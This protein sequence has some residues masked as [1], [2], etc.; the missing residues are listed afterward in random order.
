MR[1]T[2]KFGIIGC[3]VIANNK[4]MPWLKRQPEAELV[5]FCD[6]KK[7]K[8]EKAAK[9]YGSSTAK[10]YTDYREL[11]K[12]EDIDVVHVLVP[13]RAH[14]EITIAAFKA[15]KHVLCE[16]PMAANAEDAQKMI[17]AWKKTDRKFTIGYQWRFRTE[18]LFIHDMCE[19]DEL[20]DIYYAKAQSIRR[21]GVTTYGSY[22]SMEAQGGGALI[23]TG[24]HCLDLTL[25]LMNNYRPVSVSGST[26]R[27]LKDRP[28]GNANGPWD[29]AE[30]M[31]EEAGCAHIKMHNGAA[32]SLESAW[33][34]NAPAD[35][36]HLANLCGTK[37]GVDLL[38][39][40]V[41]VTKVAD[42]EVVSIK[43]DV[44]NADSTKWSPKF[45]GEYEAKNWVKS[46]I[47]DTE[48]LV[49]P[50]EALAV[51]IIIDGVYKS[52]QTGK[53]VYF[54][55]ENFQYID[56]QIQKARSRR[57]LLK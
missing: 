15:N 37:A 27:K 28:E 29:P 9:E 24:S 52:A 19:K 21:A 38:D 5:A 20:G 57:K 39:K 34:L 18:T 2:V 45:Q 17:D 55:Q 41:R 35:A 1:E 31:V 25:W 6:I 11:L 56:E 32:V 42:G 54:D 12:D 23:D 10:V 8:A 3:G 47:E 26:F 48:P 16:K 49:S 53:T 33:L 30:F 14:C 22:L 4:H 50:Y 7:E 36:P 13:N 40:E 43:P 46:L 51:S 44:P